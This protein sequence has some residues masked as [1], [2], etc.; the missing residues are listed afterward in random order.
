MSMS[1]VNGGYGSEPAEGV[2][3]R[4]AAEGVSES[5]VRP[6]LNWYRDNYRRL[7]WRED[8]DPYHV[9]I[10][11]IMLQ[12]TRIEAVI[13]YYL[14]FTEQLPDIRALSLC[15]EERLLKLWEG[16]GYY[17]RARNLKKSAG[18]LCETNGGKMY[19]SYDR[20]LTLPGI[21]PYT[22]GA[23]ASISFGEAVPAVD[24]N[25]LRV[26]ARLEA[27]R[28]NILD[29]AVAGRLGKKVEGIIPG[30][31][32][33]DFNQALMELGETICLPKEKPKCGECPI[34]DQCRWLESGLE[35]QIPVREKKTERKQQRLTV[36][37]ITDGE[38]VMIRQRP[39]KGLLAGMYEFPSQEGW[40][41]KKEA[42]KRVT[43]MG[44]QVKEIRSLKEVK[45]VFTHIEW[46]MKGYLVFVRS[47]CLQAEADD[48]QAVFPEQLKEEYAVPTAFGKVFMEVQ[49]VIND[50]E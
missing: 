11:E 47:T 37:V 20:I 21:G 35:G 26:A 2:S 16:L 10:S 38:R 40:I 44:F 31:A 18:I 36:F 30:D 6:L 28:G 19:D 48:L 23:V 22:A 1:N 45:H 42:E 41:V 39:G 43:G 25:V 3:E 49:K 7:P 14:R 27:D 24:G 32:P 29:T 50:A 13:P 5:I 33:G 8:T 9:W 4:Q 17:S 34:L 15:G 12:Q 46:R